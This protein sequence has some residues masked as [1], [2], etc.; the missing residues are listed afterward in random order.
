MRKSGYR[1]RR[2]PTFLG[3][4][5]LGKDDLEKI[6]E[7]FD[8][9][10]TYIESKF[11]LLYDK[12]RGNIIRCKNLQVSTASHIKVNYSLDG[13][14]KTKNNVPVYL[15]ENELVL[16]TA[17]RDPWLAVIRDDFS[18]CLSSIFGEQ[19]P[20]LR[21]LISDLHQNPEDIEIVI[22]KWAL[23]NASVYKKYVQEKSQII[24]MS[25][26]VEKKELETAEE[27]RETEVTDVPVVPD[28]TPEPERR[29]EEPFPIDTVNGFI[30]KDVRTGEETTLPLKERKRKKKPSKKKGV[31]RMYTPFSWQT[32]EDKAVEI[33]RIFEES[34]G[35]ENVIDVR[36]NDEE[37]CDLISSGNGE[38]RLIEI[39]AA[40][41][42]RP[43]IKLRPSQ[44]KRAKEDKE[45]YYI[46]KVEN[47]QKGKVPHIEIVHNPVENPKIRIV[48]LGECS[49]E[50]WENSDKISVDV[51][52]G[53]S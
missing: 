21:P 29:D 24:E 51:R 7:F 50:G 2:K 17:E 11:S 36:A 31:S 14:R 27:K 38:I 42:R 19:V 44:Y 13:K 47:V 16:S 28:Q 22:K 32:T 6:K 3:K 37:G 8:I 53:K 35:R 26:T 49:I 1:K 4:Q 41:E 40:K 18:K 43:Q 20:S 12:Q 46:Y 52:I 23:E 9:I 25:S 48:H 33:V 10:E 30:I 15:S 39:K 45:K 5:P 34:Q